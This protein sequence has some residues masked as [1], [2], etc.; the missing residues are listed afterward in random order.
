MIMITTAPVLVVPNNV[1]KF[2]IEIN[3]SEYVLR[4]VLSQQKIF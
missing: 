1:Y 3:A 2:W 4:E